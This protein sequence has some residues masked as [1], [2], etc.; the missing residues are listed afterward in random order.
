[1]PT[2]SH[3]IA[4]NHPVLLLM[5]TLVAAAFF[6]PPAARSQ[7]L[8]VNGS[9]ETTTPA[10][11]SGYTMPFGGTLAT[12]GVTGWIFGASTGNSYN[13]VLQSGLLGPAGV[14]EDGTNC[15]F[16]Q[17]TG[18]CSQTVNLTPGEYELTFYA[19]GR[20]QFGPNP[21]LVTVSNLLSVTVTPPNGGNNQLSDWILYTYFIAVTNSGSY[22]L[23]FAGTIPFGT[24]DTTTYIDNVSLVPSSGVPPSVSAPQPELVYAGGT[25]RF[26]VSVGGSSPFY[27]QWQHDGTN[28]I[29]GASFS[30]VGTN[31]LT[32]ADV[33][34]AVAGD[35]T[36]VVTNSLG[37]E[38]SSPASL[39]LVVPE[40]AYEEAI[41]SN[42]PV[43]YYRFNELADPSS[44]T[45]VAYDYANGYN[46]IYGPDAMD[47]FDGITGPLPS[48]GFPG[49]ETTNGAAGFIGQD[50]SS[51][52]SVE[53]WN[54]NTNTVTMTAWLFPYSGQTAFTGLIACVGG[55][56]GSLFNYTG[57][58]D[59]NGNYTLG[60]TWNFDANT[61]GW[62]SGLVP[63]LNQW[64]LVALVITPTNATVYII[65]TNGVQSSTH[66]YNHP[67]EP[68]SASGLIGNDPDGLAQR[69]FNGVMD[70]VAVFNHALSQNQLTTI[71]S[72]AS[73]AAVPLTPP[74]ILVQPVLSPTTAFL[75]QTIQTSV[76]ANGGNPLSYQW[77]GGD[78]GAFTNLTDGGG[79]SGSQASQL[80][81]ANLNTFSPTNFMVV[82][83]NSSGSV[84]SQV[85]SVNIYPYSIGPNL[86]VNGSFE[87]PSIAVDEY[88]MPFGS[89][90]AT[91]GVPGWIFDASDGDGTF[92]SFDGLVT[93][94]GALGNGKAI[95]DGNNAAYVQ[96]TGYLTQTVPLSPGKYALS[97][98]AMGRVPNGP[99]PV[100][101]T[102]S[103]VVSEG[104]TPAN[105]ADNALSDWTLYTDI[106][107]VTNAGNYTLEMAGT[108]P[109][110]TSDLSTFLDNISINALSAPGTRFTSAQVS[111]GNL[112]LSGTTPDTG[113]YY[114]LSTTNITLPLSQWTPVATN[115]FSGGGFSSSIPIS[116]PRGFF[117]IVEP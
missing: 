63:P 15:A 91:N 113:T 10:G 21:I 96:G 60:Y 24:R 26:S 30:G 104:I 58:T 89:S 82:I 77:M 5:V 48:E 52:V 23:E 110:T 11:A 59:T 25:A 101:V 86:I 70:E 36:I 87:T 90:L 29:N 116:G 71:F 40:T 93:F 112:V 81:V 27:F 53:P 102:L 92:S 28:L 75:G 108:V 66:I 8:I 106:F 9:F 85:V 46:G 84:T 19:M 111:G 98:W 83:T 16:C 14:I 100:A 20:V 67:V 39:G 109:Y 49:F 42:S 55:S 47:S 34:A 103:N 41:L 99:N 62:D 31:T 54:L 32:I 115:T 6:G 2:N 22:T 94:N 3:K 7:N 57:S 65:D 76:T 68:F 64:S 43:A 107:T 17:G 51:E 45:A 105:T 37:A 4:L 78:G 38:T 50:A 88:T 35:Y 80:T 69:G 18:W 44:G 97:I 1:M 73:G 95:E 13:G 72:A 12:N 74:S 33:S 117:I 61:Y 114:I 56:D 79:I